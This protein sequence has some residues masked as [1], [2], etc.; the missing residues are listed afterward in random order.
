MSNQYRA[1]DHLF[2]KL[3]VAYAEIYKNNKRK[4]SINLR[5]IVED[6]RKELDA[7]VLEYCSYLSGKA[8]DDDS[9]SELEFNVP[10]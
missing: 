10:I 1:N 6:N 3:F 7:M 8:Y 9:Q 4:Y 2:N 5:E